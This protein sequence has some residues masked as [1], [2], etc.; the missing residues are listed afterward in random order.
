MQIAG[1]DLGT[2]NS[3]IATVNTETG[4]VASLA[5]EQIAG[6]NLVV[7]ASTL[8]SFFYLPHQSDGDPS[9]F[10]LP[11]Q[12]EG[13][14]G[15]VGKYAK[16]RGAQVPDRLVSSAKSWLCHPNINRSERFLPWKSTGTETKFSPIE[17]S[18]EYLSHLKSA[19]L[20]Q[21]QTTDAGQVSWVVTVPASFDEVARQ[22]TVHAAE[23]VGIKNLT[24][25]EE[26]LA[27]F[28][29][30]V[31]AHPDYHKHIEPGD[32]ILVC[33]V[34]GGTTDFTLI[35]VGEVAGKLE[36]TRISVGD[37]LLL[38]G[39]NM[40]LALAVK[41]RVELEA[42]GKTIDYWQFMSL[43]AQVREAKERLLDAENALEELPISIASRG[44]S[45][46]ATSMSV[47]I[48]KTDVEALIV[49]GFFP[50]VNFNDPMIKGRVSGLHEVGLN[51]ESE[52]AVTKHLIKFLQNSALT[53]SAG[54]A[55]TQLRLTGVLFNGGVFK[56]HALRDR[57]L[58]VL[59]TCTNNPDIKILA[60]PDLEL[61]VAKGAAYY[62]FL[63]ETGKGVRIRAGVARS[64][65]IGIDSNMP[66]IP[67]Y[68][69]PVMGL[70][71]VPQGT[72]EG[73]A[74]EVTDRKFS[75]VV[76]QPVRFRFFATNTRSTDK[77]GNMLQDAERELTE[78]DPLVSLMAAGGRKS[79]DLVTVT[80]QS[81]VTETGTLVLNL[82]DTSSDASWKLEFNV[83]TND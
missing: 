76:G 56:S 74:L 37:H 34:G 15:V 23:S 35:G 71:V 21:T 66:A 7:K 3:S 29:A 27:A 6:P 77:L 45:L 55:T 30:W 69:P 26:P 25:L 62:G 10:L 53:L 17:I 60:N 18:A 1:I 9:A 81:A 31:A 20:N 19:F 51:Y 79:G 52:P 82:K 80:I 38:G 73:T 68:T 11:Q 49:N 28:Y 5:I 44:S 13:I 24:L 46:F 12:K 61:A 47:T 2:T 8:P 65:Y 22:L 40:D 42:A 70:C 14:K 32:Q 16:D 54:D 4:V 57:M 58:N 41:A 78:S 67:G 63:K 75:L 59:R 72:E 48:R 64:F 43:I 39:D 36:L 50:Q 33:D 83:R